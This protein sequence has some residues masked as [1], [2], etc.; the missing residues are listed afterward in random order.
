M[1]RDT[2]STTA[3]GPITGPSPRR[4]NTYARALIERAARSVN[5][6]VFEEHPGTS[7]RLHPLQRPKFSELLTYARPGDTVHISEMFRLVRGTVH[8][9]DVLDVFHRNRLTS[10]HRRC[11]QA[12]RC[13]RPRRTSH[14]TGQQPRRGIRL[15]R[16]TR[17]MGQFGLR[18]RLDLVLLP[19]GQPLPQPGGRPQS[20]PQTKRPLLTRVRSDAGRG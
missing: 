16:Q 13:T 1:R 15:H 9:L 8:I 5:P 10:S 20:H 14:P 18:R 4:M 6:V 3:Y 7:S 12:G 19:A 2:G 17:Q 11:E